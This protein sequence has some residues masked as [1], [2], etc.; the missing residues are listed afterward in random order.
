MRLPLL[1]VIPVILTGCSSDELDCD[2]AAEIIARC[3]DGA[4]PARC[5]D[6][7]PAAKL[8]DS[9]ECT[10][11]GG[12]GDFFGARGQGEACTWRWQCD[13]D[14]GLTCKGGVCDHLDIESPCALPTPDYLALSA[15]EKQSVLF[16]LHQKSPTVALDAYG[17]ALFALEQVL[18]FL[19]RPRGAETIVHTLTRTCDVFAEP[20]TKRV[21]AL[22]TV[23]RA[24][25][26]FTGDSPYT[27]LLAP[28][29]VPAL[30]RFSIANPVLGVSLPELIPDLEFIPGIGIKLFVDGRE[31]E[32][33]LAMNSLAG[34]G[35]DHD[36][37]L[38]D[39]TNNFSINAPDSGDPA[40]S[41][42]YDTNPINRE[43]MGHVGT[44][45]EEALSLVRGSEG[46]VP[47]HRPVSRLSR[48]N[49]DGTDVATPAGPDW[50]VFRPTADVRGDAA[51]SSSDPSIDFREKLGHLASGDRVFEIYGVEDGQEKFIGFLELESTPRPSQWGDHELFIQH[52]L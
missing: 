35:N 50:L 51:V 9:G 15:D 29:T 7:S 12:K 43:V 10:T 28:G 17:D 44:R 5:G 22:G 48:V 36:Y 42:R 13:F 49:L 31:S 47:F 26:V 19:V 27:G 6:D 21:H 30:I 2:R 41:A 24:R 25:L 14:S 1:L 16:S 34:Q 52:A 8:L 23:A 37:F 4:D 39:F 3:N 11:L 20:T 45:F 33:I 46:A 40:S 38:H 18:D 32:N